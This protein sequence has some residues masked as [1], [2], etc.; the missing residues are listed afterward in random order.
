MSRNSW[1][2]KAIVL[3]LSTIQMAGCGHGYLSIA[4]Q[5]AGELR[6]DAPD[7]PDHD[8]KFYVENLADVGV[9]YERSADRRQLVRSSLGAACQDIVVVDE[10][11]LPRG[12][13]VGGA[14][15]GAYVMR[16]KCVRV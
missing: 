14:R 6:I 11:F 5:R 4:M 7:R 3:G 8:Y 13:Y 15:A 9:D 2:C 16:I 12:T 10:L 1:W